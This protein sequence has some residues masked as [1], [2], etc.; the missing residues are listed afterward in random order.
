[1]AIQ[2]FDEAM[3]DD[4]MSFAV[5]VG[6]KEYE[7]YFANIRIDRSSV[8]NGWNVYDIRHDESGDPCEIRNGYIFINHFGTFYTQNKFS[9]NEGESLYEDEFAY[10]FMDKSMTIRTEKNWRKRQWRKQR[11]T[12]R[13]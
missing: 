11:K 12:Q 6:G 9:L 8:P 2:S 5:I 4:R 3:R 7:G 1:M 10:S 13:Q